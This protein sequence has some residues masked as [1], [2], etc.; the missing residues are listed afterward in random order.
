MAAPPFITLT[1]ADDDTGMPARFG[2]NTAFIQTIRRWRTD[3]PGSDYREG[4]VNAVVKMTNGQEYF[5]RET[6][7]QIQS[8][9]AAL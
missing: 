2:L 5:V 8:Q 1:L 7:S 3:N 9:L 6:L 4:L